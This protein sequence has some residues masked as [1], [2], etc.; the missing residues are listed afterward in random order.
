MRVAAAG[1]NGIRSVRDEIL[2]R[3]QRTGGLHGSSGRIRAPSTQVTAMSLLVLQN[4]GESVA[5]LPAL[6]AL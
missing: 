6:V 5:H 4:A 1:K 3:R 2:F